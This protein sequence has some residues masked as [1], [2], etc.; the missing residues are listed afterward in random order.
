MPRDLLQVK[1]VQDGISC[2]SLDYSTEVFTCSK[3]EQEAEEGSLG[4]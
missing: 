2:S 4:V 1:P 3:A